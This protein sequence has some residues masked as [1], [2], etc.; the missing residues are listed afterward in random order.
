MAERS[1]LVFVRAANDRPI[2][3]DEVLCGLDEELDEFELSSLYRYDSWVS[4]CFSVGVWLLRSKPC[5][6]LGNTEPAVCSSVFIVP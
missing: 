1:G 3:L 6:V 2:E 4:S 5:S